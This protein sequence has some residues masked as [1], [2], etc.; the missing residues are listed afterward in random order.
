M[1]DASLKKNKQQQISLTVTTS[2]P[3]LVC[4]EEK[5]GRK[6]GEKKRLHLGEGKKEKTA[7]TET[8]K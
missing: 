8:N 1:T 5:R 2:Y 3:H 7:S 4:V 6:K